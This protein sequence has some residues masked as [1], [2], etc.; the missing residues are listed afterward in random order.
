MD[1][2]RIPKRILESNIT[3]KRPEGKP[4]KEWLMQWKKT[5]ERF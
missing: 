5:V 2:K 4:R 3:G 1:E